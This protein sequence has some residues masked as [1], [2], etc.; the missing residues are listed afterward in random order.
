[1]KKEWI[2]HCLDLAC[3]EATLFSGARKILRNVSFS[4]E[5]FDGDLQLEDCGYTRS[6]ISMLRKNY[7]HEESRTVAVDLWRRRIEQEKYGSVG[8]TTYN[9]FV[10]TDPDKKSKRASILGP[11]IQSVVFTLLNK[12]KF[13]IDIFYR[14]TELLKKFPADL[15]FIRD[16]LL[17]PF[18]LT[19]LHKVNFHFAN[20]TWHPM[21]FVT[22]IPHL[23]EPIGELEALKLKD[24]FLWQWTVKWSARYICPEHKRGIEKFSQAMRVHKDAHERIKLAMLKQLQIYL[25]QN[26]PGFRND[27]E[28]EEEDE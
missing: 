11:C 12:K 24:K 27:Y 9:H 16:E 17:Q 20:L 28:G 4:I 19:N 22:I 3:A 1:M 25:R 18:D 2:D 7:L 26:H 14:T 23:D 10:K 13:E 5:K 15:I 8:F 21:Y 6:K